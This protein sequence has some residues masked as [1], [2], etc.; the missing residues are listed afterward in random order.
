M[1]SHFITQVV[2]VALIGFCRN[3]RCLLMILTGGG[4]IL[5]LP[6]E[7]QG[8]GAAFTRTDCYILRKESYSFVVLVSRVFARIAI[9]FLIA[10]TVIKLISTPEERY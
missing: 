6:S 7:A 5:L 3:K 10:T 1:G 2:S 8:G 9:N 4:R